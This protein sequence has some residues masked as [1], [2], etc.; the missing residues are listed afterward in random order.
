MNDTGAR[1][2]SVQG[3]APRRFFDLSVV[4]PKAIGAALLSTVVFRLLKQ[5][6]P[7]RHIRCVTQFGALFEHSP[8]IHEVIH[9]SS[10]AFFTRAL[11]DR[12]IIDLNGTLDYQP[13]RRSAPVHL[14]VLLCAR[15]GLLNDQNGPECFLTGAERQW[16]RQTLAT[17]S[18]RSPAAIILITTRTST[19]NKE[20]SAEHWRRLIEHYGQ[21]IVWLHVG[22]SVRPPIDG[23][24]YLATSERQTVALAEVVSGIVTLDTFLLH[25]AACARRNLGRVV[26]LLGS[27]RPDCVSH[28]GFRNLYVE[29]Y[30]C[31]PCGR[32]YNAHD[33]HVLPSGDVARWPNGKAV[34]WRCEHVAC[35]DLITPAAVIS[36]I[37]SHILR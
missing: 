36:A 6:Y 15:A 34:K 9:P 28:P 25:A 27:S 8:H 19:P 7:V 32:P 18:G 11:Q 33:T 22:H 29:H 2:E 20:W 4:V 21:R 23:V 12:D 13:H 16:A 37:D 1:H 31:Q 26:V 14:I 30:P 3:T 5:R 24:T 17:Y 35:M 10:P